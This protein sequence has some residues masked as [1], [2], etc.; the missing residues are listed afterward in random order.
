MIYYFDSD[1]AA[2]VGVNAAVILQNIAYWVKK[3]E[4]KNAKLSSRTKTLPDKSG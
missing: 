3:N 1:I 2:E 4:A